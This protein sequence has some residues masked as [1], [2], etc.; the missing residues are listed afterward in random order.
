MSGSVRGALGDERPYRDCGEFTLLGF[1]GTL[2]SGSN[3][4]FGKGW[5]D[6]IRSENGTDWRMKA[7]EVVSSLFDRSS[8]V[9]PKRVALM[10]SPWGMSFSTSI[11]CWI[12]NGSLTTLKYTP[13]ST[14][15]ISNTSLMKLVY[16][17]GMKARGARLVFASDHFISP[18]TRYKSYLHALQVYRECMYYE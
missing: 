5:R 1:S 13:R 7:K 10:D 12:R 11:C 17:T 16:R 14:R 18:N 9:P 8:A 2:S 6:K 15:S 3:S 4:H